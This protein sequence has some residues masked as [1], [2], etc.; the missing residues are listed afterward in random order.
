[1]K[2]LYDLL[3]IERQATLPQIEQGY[4]HTLDAYLARQGMQQPEEEQHHLRAIAEAYR[5][6]ASPDRRR[7]YDQKLMERQHA[8]HAAIQ[9]GGIAWGV[10]LVSALL[11]IGAG[12]YYDKVQRDKV[13]LAS[14]AKA[15][16][17]VLRGAG[18]AAEELRQTDNRQA[19]HDRQPLSAQNQQP[20]VRVN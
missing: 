3:G 7:R 13:R 9:G 8:R 2:T 20:A 12:C 6:L 10:L 11:L 15:K 1:M 18:V 4:R 19:H 5:L 16:A 14:A 17:D